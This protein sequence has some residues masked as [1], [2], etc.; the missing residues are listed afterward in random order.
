MKKTFLIARMMLAAIFMSLAVSAN[1]ANCNRAVDLMCDAFQKMSAEVKK[2]KTM[3]EMSNLNFDSVMDSLNAD[4]V[5]DSC[6]K[7]KL[8]T[9]DKN[10]IKKSI[11]GFSNTLVDKMYDLTGGVISKDYIKSE[12]DNEMNKFKSALDN[13][14]TFQD[15]S[16]AIN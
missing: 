3:D 4:D 16:N 2:C 7:Y 11:D 9:S 6:L 5:P 10:R 15:F 12:M 14:V 8:T 1:A 13:A